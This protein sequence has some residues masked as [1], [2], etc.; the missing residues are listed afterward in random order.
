MVEWPVGRLLMGAVKLLYNC[1]ILN[2]IMWHTDSNVGNPVWS[3]LVWMVWAVSHQQ[4][5]I[6]SLNSTTSHHTFLV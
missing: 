6:V 5:V 2:V 4:S 1:T 3:L